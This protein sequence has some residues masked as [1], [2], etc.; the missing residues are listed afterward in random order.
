MDFHLFFFS[1]YLKAFCFDC[2]VGHRVYD[3]L[4][5]IMGMEAM[6]L[7]NVYNVK[8]RSVSFVK[9][10]RYGWNFNHIKLREVMQKVTVLQ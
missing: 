1:F 2:G 8:L 4:V 3:D 10:V 7:I 9:S 5:G 6:I